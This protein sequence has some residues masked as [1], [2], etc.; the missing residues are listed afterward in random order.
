MKF[1]TCQLSLV[2]PRYKHSTKALTSVCQEKMSLVGHSKV[3]HLKAMHITRK[4][5]W[6]SHLF[7]SVILLFKYTATNYISLLFRVHAPMLA[8]GSDDPNTSAGGKVQI[9]EYNE[10][11]RSVLCLK[12]E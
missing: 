8:V 5:I 1:A 10:A 11:S 9:H 4:Y 2:F 12:I 7:K 3:Y 6:T